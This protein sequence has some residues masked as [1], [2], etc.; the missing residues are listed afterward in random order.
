MEIEVLL[1]EPVLA[2]VF[3]AAGDAAKCPLEPFFHGKI[4]QKGQVGGKPPRGKAAD[5][6]DGLQ[7]KSAA[8]G[9]VGYGG[10]GEAVAQ[11]DL[12]A[13]EGGQDHGIGVL[14]PGCGKEKD[15]G[16]V[17]KCRSPLG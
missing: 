2:M 7:R 11:N 8:V 12:P 16:L 6:T 13:L 9:L 4:E 15:L 3:I 1:L 14:G 17:R 5:L 10:I